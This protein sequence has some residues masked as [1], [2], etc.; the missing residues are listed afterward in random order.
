VAGKTVYNLIFGTNVVRN[1]TGYSWRLAKRLA[2]RHD[3]AA[4]KG[5]L[6]NGR[7]DRQKA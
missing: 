4:F 5:V 7:R 3:Q 1:A 2:D 6:H